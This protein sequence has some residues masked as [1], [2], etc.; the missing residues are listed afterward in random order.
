MASEGIKTTSLPFLGGY[1]VCGNVSVSGLG[2]MD[3]GSE[4]FIQTG[5]G[6]R[7]REPVWRVN[8]FEDAAAF[9]EFIAAINVVILA[10]KDIKKQEVDKVL[11]LQIL[12]MFPYS[13]M[14]STVEATK[15]ELGPLRYFIVYKIKYKNTRTLETQAALIFID[16][17]SP[18]YGIVSN[19][20]IS[21]RWFDKDNETAAAPVYPTAHVGYFKTFFIVSY[22]NN[23]RMMPDLFYWFE[24]GDKDG[25]VR[26]WNAIPWDVTKGEIT[27]AEIPTMF[28]LMSVDNLPASFL[29]WGCS[30]D[31]TLRATMPLTTKLITDYKIVQTL[32]CNV[33]KANYKVPLLGGTTQVANRAMIIFNGVLFVFGY[34]VCYIVTK[35]I[36]QDP[37][38]SELVILAPFYQVAPFKGGCLNQEA[39]AIAWNEL[40]VGNSAGAVYSINRVMESGSYVAADLMTASGVVEKDINFSFKTATWLR[41]PDGLNQTTFLPLKS[42]HLFFDY[43]NGVLMAHFY[44]TVQRYTDKQ[45]P[46]DVITEH[47]GY[48]MAYRKD[49]VEGSTGWSALEYP[50]KA[51]YIINAGLLVKSNMLTGDTADY[52][53]LTILVSPCISTVN[54][55]G[56]KIFWPIRKYSFLHKLCTPFFAA[57]PADVLYLYQAMH[58]S[59]DRL[60][61]DEIILNILC[62]T[63][64]STPQKLDNYEVPALLV[65]D[66]AKLGSARLAMLSSQNSFKLGMQGSFFQITIAESTKQ[67]GAPHPADGPTPEVNN[68]NS[69]FMLTGLLLRHK[70][71]GTNTNDAT[72]ISLS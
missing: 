47:D 33:D 8:L 37:K 40:Y 45:Y 48:M 14:Q 35:L 3:K 39:V 10:Y 17:P 69:P 21:I 1:K 66:T 42:I 71:I 63:D 32:L 53:G 6:V 46:Y 57:F 59:I 72:L 43:A 4:N 16:I 44:W 68:W 61:A 20:I 50:K 49:C 12:S 36:V 56:R 62:G 27:G 15:L 5:T 18:P 64:L 25:H 2:F 24:T 7:T 22:P 28:T 34:D 54:T 29:V 19:H 13:P 60:G 70:T 31:G 52:A 11:N 58:L 23:Y 38:N 9:K 67:K 41:P 55:G 26:G 51:M 65:L 30:E